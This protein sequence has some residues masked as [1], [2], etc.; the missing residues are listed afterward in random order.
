MWMLILLVLLFI[1]NI[2]SEICPA[3]E[4]ITPCHCATYQNAI[5]VDCS[6]LQSL[7]QL[8]NSVSSLAGRKISS[9]VIKNSQF[10]YIPYDLFENVTIKEIEISQSNF[11]RIGNLG[12][13][14]FKGLENSLEDIKFIKTFDRKNPL[15]YISMEH[16]N[17]LISLEVR[18]S[19]VGHICNHMFKNG[20]KSL[21]IVRFVKGNIRSVGYRAFSF[22]KNLN[23][24]DLSDNELSF[25]PR[26]ALPE[27]A[28]SLKEINLE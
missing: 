16:L 11:S 1:Q 25:I 8:T 26:W 5:N 22:L 18:D 14:Q 15:A 21:K 19:Y 7:K 27:P 10:E 9:F 28:I 12:E 6:H 13:L 17:Q 2:H 23:I 20:P 24:I 4:D 3:R